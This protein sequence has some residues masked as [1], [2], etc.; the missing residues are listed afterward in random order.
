MV[1]I[2]GSVSLSVLFWYVYLNQEW[3]N[4]I[5]M[6]WNGVPSGLISGILFLLINKYI[7][8]RKPRKN[9][10]V[11]QIIVFI[12]LLVTTMFLIDKGGDILFYISGD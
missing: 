7:L 9:L 12:L 5:V 6:F 11:I 8:L 3:G 4:Q 1:V 2:A 10:L